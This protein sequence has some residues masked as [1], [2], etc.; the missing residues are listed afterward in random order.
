ML[1]KRDI[2]KLHP[3]RKE[4]L[5]MA[6]ENYFTQSINMPVGISSFEKIRKNN[7][8]YV[9]K[10]GL[11]EELILAEADVTLFTRPRRFGKTLTMR[12][13]ESFFSVEKSS[14]DLFRGLKIS[15]NAELC[16]TYRYYVMV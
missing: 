3:K 14:G 6:V 9:D 12:M 4:N 5:Y 2:L 10:T 16:D 13:L 15:E 7:A 11:V 8:Y 1:V